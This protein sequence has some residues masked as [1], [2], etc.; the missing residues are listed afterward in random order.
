MFIYSYCDYMHIYDVMQRK[1][2][3]EQPQLVVQQK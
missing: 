1:I 3:E 2:H